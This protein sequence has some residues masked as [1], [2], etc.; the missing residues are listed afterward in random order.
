MTTRRAQALKNVCVFLTVF[1]VVYAI[2]QHA[3]RKARVASTYSSNNNAKDNDYDDECAKLASVGEPCFK[4]PALLSNGVYYGGALL[5]TAVAVPV[6]GAVA[7]V[8]AAPAVE[9]I[10][11][12]GAAAAV[13]GAAAEEAV[14]L[15]IGG[16]F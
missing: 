2:C 5:A 3:L 1:F 10:A 13:V 12:G 4:S 14:P 7:V 11:A 15:V 9:A 16:L 6:V 8:A